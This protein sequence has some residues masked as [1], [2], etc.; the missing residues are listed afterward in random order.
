MS[1][2]S[3]PRIEITAGYGSF[4][5][6]RFTYRCSECPEATFSSEKRSYVQQAADAHL[7][8]VHGRSTR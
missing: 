6:P 4:H 7:A 5:H 1:S 8:R 3:S 2:S